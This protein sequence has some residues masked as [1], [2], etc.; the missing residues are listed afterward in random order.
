MTSTA[1]RSIAPVLGVPDVRLAVDYYRDALGFECDPE[2]GIVAGV[3]DEPAVYALL[4]RGDVGLHLQIRR[5]PPSGRKREPLE[6]DAYV[7]VDDVDALHG[8]LMRRGAII[9]NPPADQTY[10]L[11]QLDVED[12]F[13]N[14]LSFGSPRE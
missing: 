8:E 3:G 12:P 11:R 9:R 5:G 13:G 10:G 1:A 7:F 2:T 6:C 14:R 4:R